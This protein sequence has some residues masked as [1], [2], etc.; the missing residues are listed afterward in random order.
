MATDPTWLS[1]FS[2]TAYKQELRDELGRLST[3]TEDGEIAE[4]DRER[5]LSLAEHEAGQYTATTVRGHV[6]YLRTTA[7]RGDIPLTEHDVDS[8]TSLLDSFRNG[9]HPD[10]KDDGIGVR[11][12]QKALRVF[13]RYHDDL[14]IA[15]PMEIDLDDQQGRELQP[16]DLLYR[17]DVDAMLQATHNIRNRA[18]ITLALATGQRI[19]ALR[20][21]RLK[22]ITM[23]GNTMDIRL[24][25]EEAALKGASGTIPLLWAKHYVREWYESHPYRDDP[26]AALFCP[27]PDGRGL[28]DPNAEAKEPMHKESWRGILN[29]IADRAGLEKK[30]YPH[31]FR[32]TA[33]TRMAT[34]SIGDQA[35]KN[36]VGWSED[37]SQFSTY[38]ALA[39][40]L[41]ND[42]IRQDLGLPTSESGVPVVGRPTL[43]ECPNCGDRLPEGAERCLTCQTAL[44]HS[45]AEEGPV[46]GAADDSLRAGYQEADDMETV[47]KIQMID[48]LLDD[49]DVRALMEQKLQD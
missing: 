9:S 19:D 23:D 7:Q 42:T 38:V 46:E 43:E 12:Y 35:I 37:S 4:S 10:V 15:D 11:N 44:T 32:A 20:T 1:A 27:L 41:S 14:G 25:E 36:L 8:L 24:N 31:L 40:E 5:I 33:I 29:R 39:D 22:H 34:Q 30:V 16:E 45:A 48:D 21:F 47:E 28:N 26:E 18:F 13:Y 2:D 3:N 6:G 49:P 17:K